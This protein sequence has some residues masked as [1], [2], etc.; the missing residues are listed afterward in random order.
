MKVR[1]NG[2]DYEIVDGTYREPRVAVQAQAFSLDGGHGRQ[3]N[4]KILKVQYGHHLGLGWH[5]QN[6]LTGRGVGGYRFGSWDTRFHA[7]EHLPLHATVTTSVGEDHIRIYL[8][9]F[10]DLWGF[11]RAGTSAPVLARNFNGTNDDWEGGGNILGGTSGQSKGVHDAK[12]HK[13]LMF[14]LCNDHHV[15][16]IRSSANGITWT[17]ATGTNFPDAAT[18]EYVNNQDEKGKLLDDGDRLYAALFEDT[19]A[20][21][22]T[23]FQFRIYDT[24]DLGTG[25]T[26]RHVIPD[27]TQGVRGF[28]HWRDITST[29]G[30]LVPVIIGTKNVY[31]LNAGTD[32]EPLL[33]D[34]IL[35]GNANDAWVAL[36]GHDGH[37]YISSHLGDILQIRYIQEGAIQIVNIGPATRSAFMPSDGLPSS[38]QG[39]ARKAISTP[40]GLIVSYGGAGSGR[41]A[42]ILFFRFSDGTWHVLYV[43]DA[44]GPGIVALALSSEGDGTMRLHFSHESGITD[45][46]LHLESPLVS[47]HASGITKAFQTTAYIEYPEDDFGDPHSAVNVARALVDADDLSAIDSGE[48]VEL[49]YGLNGAGWQDVSDIGNFVSGDLQLDFGRTNQN[50]SAS[51]EAGTPTGVSARKAQFR[52]NGTRDSGDTSQCPKI[53]EFEVQVEV[54]E[55][56]LDAIE[57]IVDLEA[58]AEGSELHENS[59]D[60]LDDLDTVAASVP[61]VA[62]EAGQRAAI[63]VRMA[64]GYPVRDLELIGGEE[65]FGQGYGRRTGFAR[66]R[67]EESIR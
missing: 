41:T 15:W 32:Y 43:H 39:F 35:R 26:V 60:V 4:Q 40:E 55:Q 23:T 6:R 64:Q 37:L 56:R 36:V 65:E 49:E 16:T 3:D 8:E 42:T 62:F 24:T 53:N 61:L 33:P 5:R 1:L 38:Y 46:T 11:F 17:N 45:V 67:L 51:T 59:E 57:F 14:A 50:V 7:L 2:N 34:G 31:I 28:E 10:G 58:T 22:G 29:G 12:T 63:Y 44:V 66:V 18:N 20:P 13:G 47:G 27:E 54:V 52:L 19:A 48:S 30:P 21:D 9:S 25:W